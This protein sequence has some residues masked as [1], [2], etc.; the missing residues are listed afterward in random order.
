MTGRAVNTF[1]LRGTDAA[2]AAER[3]RALVEDRTADIGRLLV[4]DDAALLPAHFKA[5]EELQRSR[6]VQTLVCLAYGAPAGREPFKLPRSLLPG[7]D[8][9]VIWVPDDDGVDWRIGAPSATRGHRRDGR[10]SMLE[11]LS[12]A[13]VFDQAGRLALDVPGGVSIPGLHLAEAVADEADFPPSLLSAIDGLLGPS[14]PGS[15]HVPAP[16]I[17]DVFGRPAAGRVELR[18]RSPLRNAHDKAASAVGATE[19]IAVRLPSLSSLI[20][21]R[22]PITE[23][24]NEAGERLAELR[25]LWLYLFDNAPPGAALTPA[26]HRQVVAQGLM[27]DTPGDF[28]SA[29]IGTVIERYVD[30]GLSSG[31]ILDELIDGLKDLERR[32]SAGS[33]TDH[34]AALDR[35]CPA[36]VVGRLRGLIPFPPPEAW[37]P[38]AGFV[39]T[40]LAGIAPYGNVAGAVMALAW[41]ALV[42]LT[43]LRGPGVRLIDQIGPL[44]ANATAAVVGGVLGYTA[45]RIIG[46][47]EFGPQ[48]L[49]ELAPVAGIGVACWALA[50]SWRSRAHRW[51]ADAELERIA[52][53]PEE[54]LTTARGL[55]DRWSSAI[56][57]TYTADA[58][59]RARVAIGGVVT[60]LRDRADRLRAVHRTGGRGPLAK[61]V[62]EHLTDLVRAALRPRW[63]ELSTAQPSVHGENARHATADLLARWEVHVADNGPIEPPPFATEH[64]GRVPALPAEVVTAALQATTY[65]GNEVMWQLCGAADLG[66]L[67]SRAS[68]PPSLRFAPRAAEA[69]IRDR[70]PPGTVW[71]PSPRHAGVLR[72]V[73]VRPELVEQCW[74]EDEGETPS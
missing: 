18:D 38:V 37:M 43:V 14:G 27:I 65:P 29:Q 48:L 44:A 26:Q 52:S 51:L 9:G 67:D 55:A 22:V 46:F 53:A 41:T 40:V 50:R 2:Q 68:S 35:A 74:P 15:S 25:D 57:Q 73:P 61:T 13:E 62:H 36:S 30:G 31:V 1:D 16:D 17:A 47:F 21:Q 71:V 3:A 60:E 19:E 24:V 54:L 4:L 6:L 45:G 42:T 63:R 11:I 72:L 56:A 39:A 20:W 58:L 10:P 7:Q 70:V 28:D 49:W 59:I 66:L 8:S 12:V 69:Q 33:G 32:L 34:R 5:F 23:L 64:D